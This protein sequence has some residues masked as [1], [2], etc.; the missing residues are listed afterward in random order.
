MDILFFLFV[1]IFATWQITEILHHGYIG[2]FWRN[3]ANR[4][5]TLEGCW[6]VKIANFI[7]HG[8]S[9]PFCY[10][11]W[12][13]LAVVFCLSP[14]L[15]FVRFD[16]LTVLTLFIT[17]LAV[18]RMASLLN[19]YCHNFTRTPS[20]NEN[21]DRNRETEITSESE[22]EEDIFGP[23]SEL[24]VLNK[25]PEASP[26]EVRPIYAGGPINMTEIEER[27]KGAMS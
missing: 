12:A 20:W 26:L 4:L 10:S 2:G 13:A 3:C 27:M 11:N 5:M 21:A 9:C 8:M 15:A 17:G 14:L 6:I 19:D 1:S 24:P 23:E 16:F 18:S 22:N 25:L 7:G